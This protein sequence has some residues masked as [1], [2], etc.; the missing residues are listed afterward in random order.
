MKL[1][2]HHPFEAVQELLLV[3][4]QQVNNFAEA[5]VTVCLPHG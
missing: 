1:A 2:L 4:G 3:D 5:Y